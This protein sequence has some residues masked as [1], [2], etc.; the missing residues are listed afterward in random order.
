MHYLPIIYI[1]IIITIIIITIYIIV[2][3]IY[4]FMTYIHKPFLMISICE[5]SII[6]LSFNGLHV[7]SSITNFYHLL[8]NLFL[9]TI[10]YNSQLL[11][12]IVIFLSNY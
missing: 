10:S 6:M 7:L 12:I 4:I 11:L 1:F 5:Y 9:T 8:S 2:I 3:C